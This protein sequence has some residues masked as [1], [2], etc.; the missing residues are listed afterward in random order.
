METYGSELLDRDWPG[1][2]R[3]R[4]TCGRGKDFRNSTDWRATVSVH[5]LLGRKELSGLRHRLGSIVLMGS[6]ATFT[7]MAPP[8]WD[9]LSTQKTRCGPEQIVEW[10]AWK[11]GS[12]GTFQCLRG[13][14]CRTSQQLRRTKK[15]ASG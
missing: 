10:C 1:Y 15:R 9:C 2:V 5:S 3:I 6:I 12:G 13:F 14:T 7:L 11:T 8:R 4:M